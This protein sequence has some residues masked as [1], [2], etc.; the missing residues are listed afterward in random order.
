MKKLLKIFSY[1]LATL[2]VVFA[3][4]VFVLSLPFSGWRGLSVQTGSMRPAI[5]PGALVLVHRVPVS[6]LHVGDVI[7][8]NSKVL[9]GETIT[10]RIVGFKQ[11]GSMKEIIVKGDA[12]KVADTPLLPSQVVGKVTKNVPRVG[13]VINFLHKPLGLALV[14]YLPALL[15]I[16]YEIKLMVSRLTD[17]EVAKKLKKT[18]AIHGPLIPKPLAVAA[19]IESSAEQTQATQKIR[20]PTRQRRSIDGFGLL[21]VA[22]LLTFAWHPTMALLSSQAKLTGNT[23][24]TKKSTGSCTSSSNSN[25]SI[26]INNSSNQTATSGNVNNTGNTNSGSTTSGSASNSNNT[27]INVNV[28]N[29]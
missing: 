10:H 11:L 22:C 26:T 29:C 28:T 7:T 16:I 20:K 12:N 27:N 23:I 25:T 21:I 8:Y 9:A 2:F 14:I 19:D 18:A 24:S 5:D 1:T 4:A 3:L 6:S 13:H 17:L 15:I